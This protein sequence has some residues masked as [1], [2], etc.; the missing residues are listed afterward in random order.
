MDDCVYYSFLMFAANFRIN[1]RFFSTTNEAYLVYFANL[2][3]Y[4]NF[5]YELMNKY[6]SELILIEMIIN[7]N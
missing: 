1:E 3:L 5:V 2:S 6:I 4:F 7:M